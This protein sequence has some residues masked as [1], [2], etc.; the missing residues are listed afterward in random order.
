MAVNETKQ[1]IWEFGPFRLDEAERLLLRD[2]APV[3]LTPMVFDTLVALLERSGRLV[4][5]EAL[6]ERLCPDTFVEEGTLTR[7]ISDLRKALGEEKYVETVPKR[8]YRFV[9][10]VREIRNGN[11]GLIIDKIAE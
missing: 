5:K 10:T 8:G 3:G 9:A 11:N 1:R 4:E 2:G 6:M 7:N